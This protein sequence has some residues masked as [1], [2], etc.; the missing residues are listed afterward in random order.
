MQPPS[1]APAFTALPS[2]TATPSRVSTPKGH[3][4]SRTLRAVH[5]ARGACNGSDLLQIQGVT[6]PVIHAA[7]AVR[8]A[9]VAVPVVPPV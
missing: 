5:R 8:A 4:R 7:V 6:P 2:A 9:V 1:T 3:A